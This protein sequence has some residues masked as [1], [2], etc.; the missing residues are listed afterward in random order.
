MSSDVAK[1]LQR[2]KHRGALPNPIAPRMIRERKEVNKVKYS[3]PKLNS[4]SALGSIQDV[5][6]VPKQT[7]DTEETIDQ[8]SQPAYQADE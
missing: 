4:Y 1:A 7:S 2:L 3:K 5:N 6:H 8:P